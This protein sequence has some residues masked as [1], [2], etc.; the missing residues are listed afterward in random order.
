MPDLV[1]EENIS[2]LLRL[3]L[4]RAVGALDGAARQE[5]AYFV[6]AARNPDGGY[7]GRDDSSDLYY[8]SFAL[9]LLT[10]L[11]TPDDS[12]QLAGYLRA[13]AARTD[14]SLIDRVCLLRALALAGCAGQEPPALLDGLETYRSAD[15]GYSPLPAATRSTA[16]APYLIS[17][18]YAGYNLLPPQPERLV[19]AVSALALPGGGF[20]NDDSLSS[21]ATPPTAA[22]VVFLH[23]LTGAA[24]QGALDFLLRRCCADGGFTAV[25]GAPVADLLS[26]ATALHALHTA[27]APLMS[28]RESCLDFVE[29]RWREGGG[30]CAHALDTVAD[31]EYTFYGLLALG[32][33][34]L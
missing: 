2:G 22:A 17:L 14:L 16:Y 34:L 20:A 3:R 18:A 21:G 19:A 8:T 26:T 6:R 29:Q 27:G 24:P 11:D 7:R 28:M 1:E 10:A 33:L 32:N 30:F 12:P 23:H 15:G 31:C 5:M 9:E 4:R 25:G 13:S